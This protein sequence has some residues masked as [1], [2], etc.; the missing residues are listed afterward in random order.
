MGSAQF[1]F[2]VDGHA[3]RQQCAASDR[4]LC[5][6]RASTFDRSKNA[7][8]SRPKSLMILSL[9]FPY[10]D[11][12]PAKIFELGYVAP[13]A[14]HVS[15]EFLFPELLSSLRCGREAAILVPVPKASMNENHGSMFW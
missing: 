11:D 10:S 14:L 3:Q 9:A 1:R 15:I 4:S 6:N 7:R 2:M 5:N 12:T 8:E 13:V